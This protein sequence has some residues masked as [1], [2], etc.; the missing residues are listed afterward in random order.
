V[1][2]QDMSAKR[3]KEYE[4]K[5]ERMT[6][7]EGDTGPYLQ[8]SHARMCSIERKLLESLGYP[9]DSFEKAPFPFRQELLSKLD[10]PKIFKMLLTAAFYP[11]LIAQLPQRGFEA[12]NV[13]TYLMT[14]CHEVS[15]CLDEVY[16]LGQ[17]KDIAEARFWAYWCARMTLSNGM[18]LLGLTP[19]ERM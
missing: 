4:F 5:W 14:L 3:I 18:R 19:L 6:S 7:F 12:C 16:V 1:I 11:D 8:Y 13:V 15:S 17:E 2:I 9:Q 10:H